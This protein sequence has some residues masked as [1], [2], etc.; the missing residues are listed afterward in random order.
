MTFKVEGQFSTVKKT[1]LTCILWGKTFKVP[2]GSWVRYKLELF[3]TQSRA[4]LSLWKSTVNW[5]SIVFL[6]FMGLLNYRQFFSSVLIL[7]KPKGIFSKLFS[8]L[9]KSWL[10]FYDDRLLMKVLFSAL[11]FFLVIIACCVSGSGSYVYF[12]QQFQPFSFKTFY[13]LHPD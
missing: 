6:F 3:P 10:H 1:I 11:L 2:F 5:K 12:L 7:W 8:M 13:S 4:N 9:E